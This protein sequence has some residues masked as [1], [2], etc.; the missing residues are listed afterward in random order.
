GYDRAAVQDRGDL[1]PGDSQ[2]RPL[3]HRH[4]GRRHRIRRAPPE[5]S[6]AA[7]ARDGGRRAQA[8]GRGRRVGA[9]APGQ[10]RR[11]RPRGKK[12]GTGARMT[13]AGGPLEEIAA[14]LDGRLIGGGGRVTGVSSLDEAGPADLAYA[15]GER[16]ADSARASRAAAFLVGKEIPGLERPQIVAP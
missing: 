4:R 9:Q 3:A 11:K 10:P 1:R 6:G 16:A 5:D 14:L 7:V 12:E 13:S 15:E 8:P 2:R